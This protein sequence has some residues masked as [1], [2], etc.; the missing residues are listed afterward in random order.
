MS[1][2][3]K[4]GRYNFWFTLWSQKQYFRGKQYFR[5]AIRNFKKAANGS[6]L[7]IFSKL[8]GKH[9]CFL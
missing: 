2:V 1:N 8:K 5:Y 4:V 3:D 9:L 6:V 7:K